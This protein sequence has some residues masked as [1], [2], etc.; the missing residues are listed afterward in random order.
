MATANMNGLGVDSA[1]SSSN[2]QSASS[3]SASGS[4][5]PGPGTNHPTTLSDRDPSNGYNKINGVPNKDIDAIKLFVGQIPRHLFEKELKPL[6]EQFGKIHELI[7]LKDK[8][9]GMHKGNSPFQILMEPIKYSQDLCLSSA[10]V[11]AVK[12]NQG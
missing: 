12:L 10:R 5:S 2:A 8:Y 11:S 3:A 6:F 4:S 9:T 7:V 1:N